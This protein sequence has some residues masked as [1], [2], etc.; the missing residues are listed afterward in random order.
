M[1]KTNKINVLTVKLTVH[2]PVDPGSVDSVQEAA[3]DIEQLLAHGNGLGQASIETRLNRVPAPK[4]APEA[5]EPALAANDPADD[6]L[7]IPE[8][9]RRTAE[10]EPAVAE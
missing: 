5:S 4:P 6:N 2:I 10:T 7:D 9:L 8:R 3:D 1:P